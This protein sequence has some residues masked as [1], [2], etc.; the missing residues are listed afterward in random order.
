M[1]SVVVASYLPLAHCSSQRSLSV[2]MR[3]N[4]ACFC[5]ISGWFFMFF[6]ALYFG[7]L[8]RAKDFRFGFHD[9]IKFKAEEDFALYTIIKSK[10]PSC[11]SMVFLQAMRIKKVCFR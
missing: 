4:Q 7:F 9:I 2:V 1:V 10:P 11:V 5:D 6:D 8:W 3:E